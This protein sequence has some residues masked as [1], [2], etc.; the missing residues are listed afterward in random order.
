MG[1]RC[2][3]AGRALDLRAGLL[4]E[5]V[6]EHEDVLATLT[7]WRHLQVEYIEAVEQ[8][9]TEGAFGDHALQVAVGGADDAHIDLDLTVASHAAEAA[10]T[11]KTQQFGLQ[12]R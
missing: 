11:E 1:G 2:Q 10:V 6:R 8:V 5:I 3:A 12:V 9:F 7:Q 4:H